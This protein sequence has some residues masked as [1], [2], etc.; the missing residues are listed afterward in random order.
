MKLLQGFGFTQA[1]NQ[2]DHIRPFNEHKSGIAHS[3]TCR[4]SIMAA[5]AETSRG[6][7]RLGDEETRINRAIADR[8][9]HADVEA[10]AAASPPVRPLDVPDL[11]AAPEDVANL[12]ARLRRIADETSRGAVTEEQS[13]EPLHAPRD[14]WGH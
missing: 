9:R 12:R 14:S 4:K 1:C 11:V 13:Q 3:E 7:A 6:A 10:A 2:C 8:I 5:M